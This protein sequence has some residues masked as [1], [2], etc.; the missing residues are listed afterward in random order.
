[1]NLIYYRALRQYYGSTYLVNVKKE[2]TAYKVI[3][4]IPGYSLSI[5]LSIIPENY[6][7]GLS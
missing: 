1:M 7:R 3:Y 2:A 5:Y 4:R 6:A